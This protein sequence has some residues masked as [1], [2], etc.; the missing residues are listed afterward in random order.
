[1]ETLLCLLAISD[2]VY[3]FSSIYSTYVFPIYSKSLYKPLYTFAYQILWTNQYLSFPCLRPG[4]ATKSLILY[5]SIP[6]LEWTSKSFFFPL[7]FHEI[8]KKYDI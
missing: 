3:K 2:C 5:R 6:I 4:K 8:F 1:M 7:S